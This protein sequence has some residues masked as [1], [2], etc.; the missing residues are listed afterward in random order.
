MSSIHRVKTALV[1]ASMCSPFFQSAADAISGMF[2]DAPTKPVQKAVRSES[3]SVSSTPKPKSGLSALRH[4]SSTA[5]SA[6]GAKRAAPMTKSADKNTDTESSGKRAHLETGASEVLHDINGYMARMAEAERFIEKKFMERRRE[7]FISTSTLPDAAAVIKVEPGTVINKRPTL[8]TRLHPWQVAAVDWMISR[9]LLHWHVDPRSYPGS[10]INSSSMGTGK[11]ACMITLV[12]AN[13]LEKLR[14]DET[15]HREMADAAAAERVRIALPARSRAPMR[16]TLIVCPVGLISTWTTEIGTHVTMASVGVVHDDPKWKRMATKE[17]AQMVQRRDFVVTSHQFVVR[18]IDLFRELQF[19][20]VI[21][22]EAHEMRNDQT[23]LFKEL[24]NLRASFRWAVSGSPISNNLDDLRSLVRWLRFAP[25]DDAGVWKEH[26]EL[27]S[28]GGDTNKTMSG[29]RKL[30]SLV[31]YRVDKSVLNL[32]PCTV[33]WV[34]VDFSPVEREVYDRMLRR[35]GSTSDQLAVSSL[36]SYARDVFDVAIRNRGQRAVD[37]AQAFLLDMIDGNAAKSVKTTAVTTSSVAAGIEK[38]QKFDV[39][40]SRL[41]QK[42][43]ETVFE[44]LL[45]V[46]QCCDHYMLCCGV[47]TVGLN[48]PVAA[49]AMETSG[50]N[51][52]DRDGNTVS[53][54]LIMQAARERPSTKLQKV[55]ELIVAETLCGDQ[56]GTTSLTQTKKKKC[57]VYSMWTSTLRIIGAML[58]D[59]SGSGGGGVRWVQLDGT[60]P[61]DRRTAVL[62]SFDDVDDERAPN[63]LLA[64][65][66][67]CSLGLNLQVAQVAIVVEP[68]YCPTVEA[69]AIDRLHRMGQTKPVTVYRMYVNDTIEQRVHEIQ[70]YKQR[71]ARGFLEDDDDAATISSP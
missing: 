35:S 63:V 1:S 3:S 64:S 10:G 60:M 39:I 20:R 12:L 50:G 27:S 48:D 52:D 4:S 54:Q 53:T 16:C 34:R 13:T 32:P 15:H 44:S 67:C 14:D 7:F 23:S 28:S 37:K 46:R 25:F 66:R 43:P 58:D 24:M 6:A 47:N 56:K 17:F 42:T 59:L 31:M 22:D 49:L 26:I 11:T 18:N 2:D 69:Q 71:L 33:E 62:R 41:R 65:M 5:S 30:A 21:V 9:E 55:V 70:E 57:V 45:R 8:K 36:W 40:M 61:R 29:L 51:D 19:L 68:W 38:R